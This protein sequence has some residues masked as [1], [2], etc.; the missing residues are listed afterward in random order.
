MANEVTFRKAS[1]KKSVV[2]VNGSL[3]HKR[4]ETIKCLELIMAFVVLRFIISILP[5]QYMGFKSAKHV[6]QM[7]LLTW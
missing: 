3:G 7:F 6:K 1:K 5:V 2:A 4:M